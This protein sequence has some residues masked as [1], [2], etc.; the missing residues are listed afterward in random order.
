MLWLKLTRDTAHYRPD[1]LARCSVSLL[2]EPAPPDRVYLD[3]YDQHSGG[4]IPWEK[5]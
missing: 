1:L 2:P 4:D 5:I 3:L